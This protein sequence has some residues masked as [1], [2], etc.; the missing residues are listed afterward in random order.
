M[1][2]EFVEINR[3]KKGRFIKGYH[4]NLE[5]EFKKGR[6][7]PSKGKT[8]ENYEPLRKSSE[9]L[10]GD[11]HWSRK[12][13]RDYVIKKFVT[14]ERNNKIGDTRRKLYAEGKIKKL[15]GNNNPAKRPEV[16]EKQKRTIN[17]QEWKDTIGNKEHRLQGEIVKNMWKNPNSVYNTPEFMEKL[18]KGLIKRPTSF[19]QNISE[20]CI[21]NNLPF[22]YTG[23]GTFFIGRKNPDFV[24][25]KKRI[26]IEVF[27]SFFKERNYVSV[28]EYKKQRI[29]YFERYGYKVIFLD[30]Y[31]ILNK[32]WENICIK[33]IRE[34]CKEVNADVRNFS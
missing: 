17:S 30:E 27:Y 26:A 28:E 29:E 16:I 34:S 12:L 21:K 19:E 15:F 20:L 11:S 5:T 18:L 8:K 1:D 10:K 13:D 7:E 31:D 25:K 4:S 23:N 22:I 33:K 24:D 2:K 3:D 14:V 6:F 32:D 9:K